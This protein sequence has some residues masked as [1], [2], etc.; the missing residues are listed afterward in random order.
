[1]RLSIS[2]A[3]KAAIALLHRNLTPAGVLAASASPQAAKRKYTRI[4]GRD[5]AICALGM[6]VSGDP[7]LLA[8]ARSGLD[9][10]ARHQAANGQ[11]PKYVDPDEQEVDFWYVGC[12]DATLWWLVAVDFLARLFPSP[13]WRKTLD[14]PV[15]KALHWL[16]CQEHPR[17]RLLQQNEASDWADIMPRSGYVLYGNA[18]WYYVKQR[19]G[20][21][22][23]EETKFHFTHLFYPFSRDVPDYHRL[24]L[25][26]SYAREKGINDGL[27]LSFVNFSFWGEEG[28]VFGNLLAVLLGL[29]DAGPAGRI[30]RSLGDAQ[31]AVPYP[32]R[33][34]CRPIGRENPLWRDY[35]DRH[36]QN[37]PFGYHNGGIWPFIG[38]FWALALA[39]QNRKKDAAEALQGMVRACSLGNWEFNEWLD[40]RSGEPRGMAGQSWNAAMLLLAEYGL[41]NPVFTS[42]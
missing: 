9:A 35:M 39:A 33:A 23:A 5:H 28:D 22:T 11:I 31:V 25:L 20:L 40:G 12:I 1:M 41:R 26:T 4:F 13:E 2:T 8:G 15:S 38:G 30:L 42:E 34:V 14:E 17:L 24:R 3:V 7:D 37:H 19:Y 16:H 18:L 27:F 10:L 21:P 6:A 36:R 29:V 32:V